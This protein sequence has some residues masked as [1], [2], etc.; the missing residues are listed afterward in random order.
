MY[1]DYYYQLTYLRE[2]ILSTANVIVSITENTPLII[3]LRENVIKSI[4][5]VLSLFTISLHDEIPDLPISA[6]IYHI[7]SL[8]YDFKINIHKIKLE[9]YGKPYYLS[10][11][12]K[13]IY[14]RV[15]LL[16][17]LNLDEI[18]ISISSENL[19]ILFELYLDTLY[20]KNEITDG[21][22][23]IFIIDKNHPKNK[24]FQ[25]LLEYQNKICINY[26][27]IQ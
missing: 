17:S 8:T 16:S 21:I 19:I 24:S 3:E 18:N 4:F 11:K 25:L 15:S 14:F 23:N 13:F 6:F 27:I 10:K 1:N 5:D 12:Y 7:L 2:H 26:N 9:L 22:N 20:L